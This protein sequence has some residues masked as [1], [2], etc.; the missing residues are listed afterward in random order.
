M[1]STSR[2]SFP[3]FPPS[4][5]PG[6]CR[7]CRHS[8]LLPPP[9]PPLQGRTGILKVHARNKKFDADIDLKEIALRTPGFSGEGRDPGRGGLEGA[10]GDWPP[11]HVLALARQPA[12]HPLAQ[13][14]NI[15]LL[16]LTAGNVY[17]PPP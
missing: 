9:T 1:R 10:T 3:P 2:P 17:A 5:P 7:I 14:G 11:A 13:L 15:G 6:R 4:T 12:A 16:A 8:P